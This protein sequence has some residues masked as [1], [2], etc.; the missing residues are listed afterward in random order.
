MTTMLMVNRQRPRTEEVATKRQIRK[1]AIN[2]VA[3]DKDAEGDEDMANPN[4]GTSSSN[5]GC[6]GHNT[7][8]LSYRSTHSGS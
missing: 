1:S 3:V 5:D 2:K 4:A 7:P 8:P 6:K